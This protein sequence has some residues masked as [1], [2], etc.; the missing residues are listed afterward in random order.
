M[1]SSVS[2]VVKDLS[3]LRRLLFA[4]SQL[5]NDLPNYWNIAVQFATCGKQAYLTPDQA[6]MLV[7]NLQELDAKAF[8]TDRELLQQLMEFQVSVSKPP[9]RMILISSNKE[10]LLCGSELQLRKDRFAPLVLYDDVMGTISA[11]HYHKYCTNQGCGLTQYYGYHTIDGSVYF[12]SNWEQL[13]F[14]VSSRESGFSLSLMK[15]FI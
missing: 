2:K 7:E 12:D 1:L 8:D 5:P 9:I 13:P 4:V 6:K 14:F 10:C 15:R 3:V 11:S